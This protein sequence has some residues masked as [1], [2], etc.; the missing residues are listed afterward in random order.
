MESQTQRF[1]YFLTMKVFFSHK[2]FVVVLK[3]K[4]ENLCLNIQI[5][6]YLDSILIHRLPRHAMHASDTHLLK[7]EKTTIFSDVTVITSYPE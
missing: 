7:E 2:G 4:A 6:F 1:I 5:V 3:N